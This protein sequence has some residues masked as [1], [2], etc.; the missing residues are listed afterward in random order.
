MEHFCEAQQQIEE[1]L[2]SDLLDEK[3][4]LSWRGSIFLA[5]NFTSGRMPDYLSVSKPR[6]IRFATFVL[7]RMGE[8]SVCLNMQDYTLKA[9]DALLFSLGVIGE[10]VHALADCK[11]IVV[12]FSE[13]AYNI[14]AKNGI[15]MQLRNYFHLQ[16]VLIHFPNMYSDTLTAHY[17]LMRDVV[18][19]IE[20]SQKEEIIK[21]HVNIVSTYAL[22]CIEEAR[23]TLPEPTRYE[24]MFDQFLRD[25]KENCDKNR[26]VAF[27]A[28]R[29]FI[30]PKYLS[31]VVMDVSGRHPTDWIRDY[32]LLNAKALL[33]NEDL[34]VQ[35]AS[36]MLAFPNP[37]FFGKYFKE[38]VGCTPREY[39]NQK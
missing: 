38:H 4:A 29:L 37:S 3:N 15:S 20:F 26:T 16:P 25:V 12:A 1:V 2:F 31:K 23:R 5:D 22:H 10:H 36:D 30:S 39:Q 33:R 6:K 14:T 7:C 34:S 21:S 32:I 18:C 17:H 8:I 19:D 28:D 27:Y 9:D 24:R 11:L 35:Q 13:S